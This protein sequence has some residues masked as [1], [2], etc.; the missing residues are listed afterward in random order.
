MTRYLV[1]TK[2]RILIKDYGSLSFAKNIDKNVV[3]NIRKNLK[4]KYSQNLPDRAK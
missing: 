1:Q 2:D 4:G 3:K